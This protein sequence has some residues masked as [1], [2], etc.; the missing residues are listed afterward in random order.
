MCCQVSVEA[1]AVR[2]FGSAPRSG[3]AGPCGNSMVTAHGGCSV[4]P[5]SSVQ[6]SGPPHTPLPTLVMFFSWFFVC[7][8]T[9][10]LL[11]VKWYLLAVF[12]LMTDML[13]HPGP[14]FCGGPHCQG[15]SACF[16]KAE[17]SRSI[18]VPRLQTSQCTRYW[19]APLLVQRCHQ[20][21]SVKAPHHHRGHR[22]AVSGCSVMG[23][24]SGS[25][26]LLPEP[27]SVG[28]PCS[29][30]WYNGGCRTARF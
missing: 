6:G 21:S 12:F 17:F 20:M 10:F 15:F 9:T 22:E 23:Q 26:Q 16:L 24:M 13:K 8:K 2:S 7:F 11:D 3:I 29:H 27:A 19:S 30:Q 14:L 18:F 5:H 1:P 25:T 4:T 28:G